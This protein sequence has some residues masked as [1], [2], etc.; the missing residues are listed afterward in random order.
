MLS[1]IAAQHTPEN[2]VRSMMH[3][4]LTFLL[5]TLLLVGALTLL[6]PGT[7]KTAAQ[8][9]TGSSPVAPAEPLLPISDSYG[10]T[11][12]SRAFDPSY[13]IASSGTLVTLDSP[14]DAY[15]AVID[16]GFSFPFYERAFSQVKISTNG[17]LTFDISAV[18]Q[19]INNLKIPSDQTPNNLIAPFWDDLVE[20]SGSLRYYQ[21]NN[22]VQNYFGVQ[23]DQFSQ[24]NKTPLDTFQVILFQNGDILFQ[25]L[26]MNSMLNEATVGFEDGD[27]VDGY[28]Y[29]YNEAGVSSNTAI[30]FTRPPAGS[31]VKLSPLYAGG[32]IIG[33]KAQF[34]LHLTNTGNHPGFPLDNY[35][36]SA[37]PAQAGWLVK[38]FRQGQ[39]VISTGSLA[40]LQSQ[41]INVIVYPPVN[42]QVGDETLIDLRATSSNDPSRSAKVRLQVAV[43]AKFMHAYSDLDSTGKGWTHL[44]LY[45]KEN[46]ASTT[47][48]P[49]ESNISLVPAGEK[50][51]LLW[52]S[53]SGGLANLD[54]VFVN[55][56]GVPEPVVR[57]L[58]Q[59]N[60]TDD[61][62]PYLASGFGLNQKVAVVW[63][64]YKIN[65]SLNT[66]YNLMF[67]VLDPVGTSPIAFGPRNVTSNTLAYEDGGDQIQKASVIWVDEDKLW[68]VWQEQH[69]TGPST[70]ASGIRAGLYSLSANGG[71]VGGSLVSIG[72]R[73]THRWITPIPQSSACQMGQAWPFS[74]G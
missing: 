9:E 36:L 55:E 29:L 70:T 39:E 43:P 5:I 57:H 24:F 22:G 53:A 18:E 59:D 67:A 31:R 72:S 32:F 66:L 15:S 19:L 47:F 37:Q 51:V 16:L 46:I 12:S 60:N 44:G 64:S 40:Q 45:W 69:A 33:G 2:L 8:V 41:D 34:G 62:L 23:W 48:S 58:E 35:S 50:Y 38:F 71:R 17:Y 14:D 6:P 27:G 3:N 4:R 11:V 68:F 61:R 21:G 20:G 63:P 56:L 7:F 52:D 49:F 28:Q 26:S 13:P 65:S 42:A 10:Y 73:A 30:L 74:A 25:Y 54:Y 1:G